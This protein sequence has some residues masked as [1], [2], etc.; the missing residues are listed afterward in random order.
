MAQTFD[1]DPS[2]TDGSMV[3]AFF[4]NE[5]DA[6]A[7][8]SELREAGFTSDQIGLATRDSSNAEM[9]TTDVTN[10]V[11]SE[12]GGEHD[13]S[14]W[15]NVKDFF[16]GEEHSDSGEFRQS[17]G[18]MNFNEDRSDY[19]YRG[20]GQGGALVSVRAG[21]GRQEEARRILQSSGGDLRDSGFERQERMASSNERGNVR[22]IADQDYRVQLRGEMLQAHKERV[23]RGEVRL[24]K[25]VVSENRSI[26]VPVTREELVI[27]RTEASGGTP[28]GAIGSDKEIRVPLSEERVTVEK[29]PIVTGEVKVGKRQVQDTKTISD[30]VRHEE[31]RIDKDGDIDVDDTAVRDRN[32]KIA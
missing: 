20:I 10:S 6:Y 26:E 9:T 27:E 7:A 3:V 31:A 25:E 2:M 30:T 19:Y 1:R 12:Q 17:L 29:T 21:S 16:T 23:N 14:F 22:N 32:R 24:R 4:N 18:G 13:R 15:Q 28:T 5:K 8:V 11:S